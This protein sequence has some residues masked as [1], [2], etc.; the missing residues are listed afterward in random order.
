MSS[1]DI[2]SLPN[3]MI[4]GSSDIHALWLQK[5]PLMC[6]GN[7][8]FSVKILFL[9]A[10]Y[11][12]QICCLGNVVICKAEEF[13]LDIHDICL[14]ILPSMHSKVSAIIVTSLIFILNSVSLLTQILFNARHTV[15]FLFFL[16]IIVS[17]SFVVI[18]F[19]ILLATNATFAGQYALADTLWRLSHTCYCDDK[20]PS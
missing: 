16:L 3:N 10:T 2:L 14:D 4:T 17:N 11:S 1:N 19:I 13:V 12:N 7:N 8:I 5:N 6:L 20:C 9:V 15:F 18:Y